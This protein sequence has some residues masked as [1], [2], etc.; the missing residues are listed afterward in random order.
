MV[1]PAVLRGQ[2]ARKLPEALAP[3]AAMLALVEREALAD[4][5]APP[6]SAWTCLVVVGLLLMT[7]AAAV[8]GCMDQMGQQVVMLARLVPVG[9]RMDAIKAWAPQAVLTAV[10]TPS[11]VGRVW[12]HRRPVMTPLVIGHG[13]LSGGPVSP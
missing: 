4:W 5:V 7:A 9:K 11:L 2:L 1:W 6:I 12:A 13:L 3:Q 8:A 10:V